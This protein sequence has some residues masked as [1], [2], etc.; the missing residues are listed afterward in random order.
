MNNDTFE[1]EKLDISNPTVRRYI[2]QEYGLAGFTWVYLPHHFNLEPADFHPDLIAALEDVEEEMVEII[3]FRGSAKSTYASLAYI[4]YIALEHH[5]DFILPVF[6][7]SSQMKLAIANMRYELENNAMLIKDYG[8]TF[9]SDKNWSDSSLQLLNGVL[10]MGRSRGQKIRG[11]KHRQFRPQ[12]II[13]DDPEDLEWV[14]TK[15]NRDKTERWMTGEVIPAQQETKA[16]LILIGN[17]LHN[18]ALM[19]RMEAKKKADGTPLFKTLRFALIDPITKKCTWEGKYPDEAAIQAQKDKVGSATAWSREYLLKIIAEEDQ[20][21]KEGD[22]H[23][24]KNGMLDERDERDSGKKKYP[25]LDAGGAQDLAISEKTTADF[26]AI[27]KGWMIR[28]DEKRR[29]LIAPHPFNQ[30]VDFDGAVEA[31]VTAMKDMPL[32][33]RLY[34]E[35]VM[36][37]RAAVQTIK[38]RGISCFGV[39]PVSDKRA[40]LQ[41]VSPYIKDGTVL[42]PETGCEVLID[43]LLGFGTEEHDDL[44]DALVYLILSLINKPSVST[45]GKVGKI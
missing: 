7:T 19:A 36:Y 13:I 40:R 31:A 44:V 15:V 34:V 9:S 45:G 43:Q 18:N 17:L 24:Y 42:F 35:D 14:K 39:K 26:T 37:Q 25:I 6:D 33:S 29:L 8:I 38:K 16:K 12:V 1:L 28:L 5:F 20:I 27:V 2:V 21:I 3:G 11:L 23:R 32:G 4:L 30:R 22:I 41:A 10:I